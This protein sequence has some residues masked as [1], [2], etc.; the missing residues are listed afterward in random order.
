ICLFTNQNE[1][2]M[3]PNMLSVKRRKMRALFCTPPRFVDNA[4][5]VG[6]IFKNF[7][8]LR[9]LDLSYYPD[10]EL[11]SSIA[12]LK[13]LRYLN[14]SNSQL[15]KLPDSITTLYNLQILILKN[16][17][18]LI[19]LPPDMRKLKNLRFLICKN[20]KRVLKDCFELKEE[21]LPPGRLKEIED[22]IWEKGT[23]RMP[24]MPSKVRELINLQYLPLFSV[25]N[26]ISGFG[27]EELST[28]YFL[29]RKLHIYNL[30]NVST[31]DEAEGARIG[32]KQHILWLELHWTKPG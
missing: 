7:L 3:F 32:G 31:R 30:E 1:L 5:A 29:G 2:S 12:G 15:T 22:I 9:V 28:L 19:Y 26:K 23:E 11:P 14:L 4:Y 18:N 13:Y 6:Q 25:G 8:C 16:C 10:N 21:D 24:P 20:G 27:I 17:F